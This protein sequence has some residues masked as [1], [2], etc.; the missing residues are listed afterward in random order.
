LPVV[1]NATDRADG[2]A[3]TEPPRTSVDQARLSAASG[4]FIEGTN[5]W[6]TFELSGRHRYPGGCPLER[7]VRRH[8]LSKK[9]WPV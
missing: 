6:L 9:E 8:S 2:G 5:K 1:A 4:V 3:G 7:R